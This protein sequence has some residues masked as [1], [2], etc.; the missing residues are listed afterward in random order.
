MSEF[1]DKV[2]KA[3]EAESQQIDR[4]VAESSPGMVEL[5]FS[6]F[7]GR[8]F[9]LNMLSAFVGLAFLILQ[10]MCAVWFFGAETTKDQIMFATIFMFCGI[11]L[12]MLKIW[13]WMVMNRNAVTREIKRLELRVSAMDDRIGA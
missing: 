4:M 10:V 2:R 5:A 12:M 8:L 13:F 1:D 11:T 3:L 9:L 7:R 6:V